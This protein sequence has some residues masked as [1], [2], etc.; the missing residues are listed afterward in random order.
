MGEL[1]F[2]TSALI[3]HVHSEA[4]NRNGSVTAFDVKSSIYLHVNAKKRCVCLRE[5]QRGVHAE[6][7]LER[8]GTAF[9]E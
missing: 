6:I 7:F 8:V 4:D 9:Q 5:V 1:G 2:A 3:Y